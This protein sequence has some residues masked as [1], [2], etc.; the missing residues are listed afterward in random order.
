M[1]RPY[2]ALGWLELRGRRHVPVMPLLPARDLADLGPKP[3]AVSRALGAATGALCVCLAAMTEDTPHF[4][5]HGVPRYADGPNCRKVFQQKD[6]SGTAPP[7]ISDA[8]VASVVVEVARRFSCS[9]SP[10]TA[11]RC[12]SGDPV[13]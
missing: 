3:A 11:T 10:R 13:R 5:A 7:E 9:P 4:H 12:A 1:A 8:A 2:P 6:Q